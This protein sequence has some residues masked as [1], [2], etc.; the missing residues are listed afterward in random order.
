MVLFSCQSC[1]KK[2]AVRDDYAGLKIMCK[3][4]DAVFICPS[5]SYTFGQDKPLGFG[6]SFEQR[7]WKGSKPQVK[8]P[9]SQIEAI[10]SFR[11]F[12]SLPVFDDVNR[13]T[14]ASINEVAKE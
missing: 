3:K 12:Q 14:S 9:D 11:D 2:Y 5:E 4:C 6:V 7:E 10:E 8:Y 13:L 1:E